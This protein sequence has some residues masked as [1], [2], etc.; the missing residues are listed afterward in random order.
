MHPMSKEQQQVS[1]Y[2]IRLTTDLRGKLEAIAK[3]NGRS[4]NAEMLLRLEL[5]LQGEQPTPQGVD[6]EKTVRRITLE[7][8]R[9][10]LAKSDW[11]KAGLQGGADTYFDEL[12]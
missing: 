10:A 3:A 8:I 6:L 11:A 12:D 5:S 7:V 4:L 1:P 2:P 9:E